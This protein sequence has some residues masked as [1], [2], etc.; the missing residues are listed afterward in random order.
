MNKGGN[1]TN[2]NNFK[3]SSSYLKRITVNPEQCGG[4]PCIPGIRL[5]VS[6]ILDLLA[7][8]ASFDEIIVD[9]GIQQEDI[10]AALHYAALQVDQNLLLEESTPEPLIHAKPK[11]NIAVLDNNECLNRDKIEIP[12]RDEHNARR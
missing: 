1:A 4:L 12:S 7:S 3:K 2:M 9:Y 11:F 5:R 10:V 8:G 6:D